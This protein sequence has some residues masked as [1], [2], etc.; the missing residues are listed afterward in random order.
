MSAV[1]HAGG[2][3]EGGNQKVRQLT[4]AFENIVQH[5]ITEAKFDNVLPPALS[6]RHRGMKAETELRKRGDRTID[7]SQARR[8]N[9]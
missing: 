7:A 9:P 8:G 6:L 5:R 2:V 3:R 1:R 4:E